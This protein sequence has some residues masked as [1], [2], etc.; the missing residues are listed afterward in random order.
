MRRVRAQ[1]VPVSLSA[2]LSPDLFVV[3]N[4]AAAQQPLLPQADEAIV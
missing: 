1:Q 2:G 3:Y 4:P